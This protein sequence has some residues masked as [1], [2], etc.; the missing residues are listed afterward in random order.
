MD[1]GTFDLRDVVQGED[2]QGVTGEAGS[3][4]KSDG[5]GHLVRG[6]LLGLMLLGDWKAAQ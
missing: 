6:L 3:T 4:A 1:V 5:H 2:V